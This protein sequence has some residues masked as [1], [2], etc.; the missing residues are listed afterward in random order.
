VTPPE[1]GAGF[2][3]HASIYGSDDEFAAMAVPFIEDGLSRAEPVLVT[4]TSANLALLDDAMGPAARAVDS[5]ESA[6]FGRRP[7][8]RIAAFQRYWSGNAA[9][10]GRG[11]VRIIAEPIWAGR[12]AAEVLA[13][14]RMESGL[15]VLLADTNIHMVCPYDARVADPSIVAAARRT[16]PTHIRGRDVEDCPEFVDPPAFARACD[17]EPLP[18]PPADAARY[19]VEGDL[20]GLRRFVAAE[21]AARGLSGEP[22]ALLLAAAGEVANDVVAWDGGRAT[23]R[24]WEQFGSV[25]VEFDDRE[26]SAGEPFIGYRQPDPRRPAGAGDGLWLARQLCDAVEVRSGDPGRTVRLRFPSRH[27]AESPQP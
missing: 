7:P 21:A 13:W 17:A 5:A 23:V 9:A 26:A 24:M 10:A 15:N 27:A 6:Y 14:K 1:G 25:V 12:S 2:V 11:N 18:E 19:D 16:H 4:T 8:Q 20:R 3:H 22:A